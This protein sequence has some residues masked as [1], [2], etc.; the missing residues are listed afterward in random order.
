MMYLVLTERDPSLLP[1]DPEEQK[2]IMTRN[3]EM[4]KQDLDSGFLKMVGMSPN[5][6][7][8][9]FIT[10]QDVDIKT[11]YMRGQMA[12]PSVKMKVKPMLS[13]DEVMDAM[14]GMQP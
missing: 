10:D 3:M 5:G 12:G 4:V 9:C 14:K 11:L 1:S 2:K 8:A 6:R 13:F 7:E